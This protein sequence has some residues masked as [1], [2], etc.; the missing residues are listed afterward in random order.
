MAHV[1][2]LSHRRGFVNY[3]ARNGR[4]RSLTIDESCNVRY[5]QS[6]N[7]SREAAAEAGEPTFIACQIVHLFRSLFLAMGKRIF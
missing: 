6:V 7:F 2:G 3:L 4:T 1:R 5:I